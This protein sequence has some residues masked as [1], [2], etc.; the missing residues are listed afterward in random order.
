MKKSNRLEAE[1]CI[2]LLPNS[3]KALRFEEI[4]SAREGTRYLR[5]LAGSKKYF[6]KQ[7]LRTGCKNGTSKLSR[8][9]LS[10]DPAKFE[11]NILK[12]Y[13]ENGA[14]VSV[15]ISC[16]SELDTIVMEDIGDD[17]LE[18]RL[19]GASESK[20]SDL[21][22]KAIAEMVNLHKVARQYQN[23]LLSEDS[24]SILKTSMLANRAL[25]YYGILIASKKSLL[26]K[27]K[28]KIGRKFEFLDL[29]DLVTRNVCSD[30]QLVHGDMSSYHIFF[31]QEENGEKV[32][33][34]DFGNPK[35]ASVFI[36]VGDLLFSPG[37]YLPLER[38]LEILN[39]YVAKNKNLGSKD[40]LHKATKEILLSEQR[41]LCFVGIFECLR[42]AARD[43]EAKIKY[44]VQSRY[45]ARK[46]PAY[47]NPIPG[48]AKTSMQLAN[49]LMANSGRY[50][51]N[52]FESR[53]LERLSHV[54]EEAYE[55][56]HKSQ[57]ELNLIGAKV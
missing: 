54:L 34:I 40:L 26:Q 19:L 30:T 5:I 12:T 18:K 27:E 51:L 8:R 50:G 31:T 10:S 7:F 22:S 32:R 2:S 52:D 21:L 28:P 48:Y 24:P 25:N 17:T 1:S 6:V 35:F 38:R 42:R 16:S 13:S 55:K 45:F 43:K 11:Y 57:L 49:F 44:P 9:A 41:R 53:K 33:F 15:P 3:S 4:P 47:E 37:I 20:T 23:L 36:D 56:N 29:F 14:S 46:H 39:E